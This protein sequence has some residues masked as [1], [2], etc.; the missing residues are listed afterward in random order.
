MESG[1]VY[2]KRGVGMFVANGAKEKLTQKRKEAFFENYVKTMITE[3]AR[4]GIKKEDI[5]EMLR[6]EEK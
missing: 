2:K 3:A 6:E 1:I 4:L 5:I